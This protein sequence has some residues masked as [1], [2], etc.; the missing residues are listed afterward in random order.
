LELTGS[1]ASQTDELSV[2]EEFSERSVSKLIIIVI[3]IIINKVK[4]ETNEGKPFSV[5]H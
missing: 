1:Q 3:I 5:T 4:I 2:D